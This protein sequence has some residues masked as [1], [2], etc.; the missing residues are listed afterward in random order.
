M[1]PEGTVLCDIQWNSLSLKSWEA[2]FQRIER[3]TLLQSY[4]YAQAAAPYYGQKPKWGFIQI[5][6]RDAGMVQIMEAGALGLHGLVLD[7]G[8]LWFPGFG[9]HENVAAFF[10]RFHQI[11]PRRLG[12]RRRI[13]PEYGPSL[14][15]EPFGYKKATYPAYQTLWWDLELAEMELRRNLKQKW[16]NAL[17]KAE[18]GP[19]KTAL[20]TD[21]DHWPFLA[22][23]YQI[24]KSQ[25]G[26]PGANI[27]FLHKLVAAFAARKQAVLAIAFEK[28]SPVAGLL[29]LCHGCCAT[30]QMAVTSFEG[31]QYG[32][33]PLLLW[34]AATHLKERGI[35]ALDLGGVNDT[36][37]AQ[38]LKRFKQGTG[39][40]YAELCGIYH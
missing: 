21:M 5:N 4:P 14:D 1:L 39:A 7:R 3:S 12:R 15:L 34:R 6:G 38:G 22:S 8:P 11:Y 2:H 27:K 31:R 25:R 19:L 29:I 36:Q 24:D 18:K 37:D 35:K 9:S 10:N 13:I 17:N 23:L 30:L 26:Y 32:A 20:T 28:D 33:H 16:R 40:D